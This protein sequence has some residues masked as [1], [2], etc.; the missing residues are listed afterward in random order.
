[1]TTSESHAALALAQEF[2]RAVE[3]KDLDSVAA[4]L[5]IDTRQLFMHTRVTRTADGVADVI[6]GGKRGFCVADVQG[7]AEVLAYTAALFDKFTPLIWRD[8]EWTA[9]EHG[10]FFHGKGDMVVARTGKAYRNSYVT[11]FDVEDGKIVR[12]AEYADALLYAR[13]RVRPNGAEFRALL[14]AVRHLFSPA[15]S[16]CSS[17]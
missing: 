10:I 15:R 9:S 6:S 14:R 16:S 4:T 8:H 12:M 5:A 17:R 7:K 13:L 3:A 2:V 11:R 1:M